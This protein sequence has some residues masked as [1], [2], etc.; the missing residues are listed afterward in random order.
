MKKKE[1]RNPEVAVQDSNE[2]IHHYARWCNTK[3]NFGKLQKLA[4]VRKHA[5]R[6]LWE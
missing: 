4:C 2:I 6:Q 5:E 3:N 1:V